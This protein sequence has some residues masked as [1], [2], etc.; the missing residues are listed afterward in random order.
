MEAVYKGSLGN[1]HNPAV[2]NRFL[3]KTRTKGKTLSPPVFNHLQNQT[4]QEELEEF[5]KKEAISEI[6]NSHLDI[7]SNMLLVPKKDGGQGP[8]IDL[9]CLNE[10]HHFKM[11]GL[12]MVKNYHQN[13]SIRMLGVCYQHK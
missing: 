2:C 6:T 3:T 10:T 4:I 11:E 12:H 7:Y 9:K 5:P 13:I 1:K 8:V